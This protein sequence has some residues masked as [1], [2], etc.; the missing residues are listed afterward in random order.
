M[1]VPGN[2]LLLPCLHEF[3]LAKFVKADVTSG[4]WPQE[5]V[6]GSHG[7]DHEVVMGCTAMGPPEHHKAQRR[8]GANGVHHSGLGVSVLLACLPHLLVAC[9]IM[10]LGLSPAAPGSALCL[11]TW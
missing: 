11:D 6:F 2:P 4:C 8:L 3:A 1:W 7:G 10:G 5:E 9:V